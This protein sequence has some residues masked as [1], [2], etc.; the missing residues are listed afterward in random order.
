[1]ATIF[2]TISVKMG[3][4]IS[5]V[6]DDGKRS[7]DANEISLAFGDEIEQNA[8]FKAI[9]ENEEILSS[10]Q[11]QEY[12]VP[13]ILKANAAKLTNLRNTITTKE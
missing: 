5:L 13:I 3:N 11:I 7:Q 8:Q 9:M 4:G 12:I 2:E 1:M 6:D 10:K